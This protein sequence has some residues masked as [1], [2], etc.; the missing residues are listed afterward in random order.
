MSKLI[1]LAIKHYW[2]SVVV[3][4]VVTCTVLLGYVG[5]WLLVLTITPFLMLSAMLYVTRKYWE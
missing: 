3:M 5:K 4:M 1:L 2:L